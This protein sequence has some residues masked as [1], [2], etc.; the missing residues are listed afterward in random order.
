MDMEK[1]LLEMIEEINPYEEVSSDTKL[2]AEG[3]LDSL[4][5]ILLM[6]AIE[7]EFHIKV[8]EEETKISNFETI[9]SIMQMIQMLKG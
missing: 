6:G 7:S 8:P 2:I 4:T 9:D 5:V 1:R 3:I